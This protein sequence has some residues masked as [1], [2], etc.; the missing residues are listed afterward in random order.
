MSYTYYAIGECG[1]EVRVARWKILEVIEDGR[2]SSDVRSDGGVG[3]RGLQT[4]NELILI[5]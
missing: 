3:T 2:E 1:S 4:K 5:T